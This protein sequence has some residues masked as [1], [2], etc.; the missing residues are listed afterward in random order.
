MYTDLLNSLEG[1][2]FDFL[3]LFFSLSM[4][5]NGSIFVGIQENVAFMES[6]QS[7][8]QQHKN[9]LTPEGQCSL[10]QCIC[11]SLGDYTC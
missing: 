6:F 8:R 5:C 4:L 3:S 10:K 2:L 11:N 7:M 1:N 9:M